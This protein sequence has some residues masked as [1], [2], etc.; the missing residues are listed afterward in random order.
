MHLLNTSRYKNPTI[1]LGSL[2]LCLMTFSFFQSNW[3]LAWCNLRTFPL[4]LSL[5]TT[6]F[7][8]F[9][10]NDRFHGKVEWR[11]PNIFPVLINKIFDNRNWDSLLRIFCFLFKSSSMVKCNS[12]GIFPC[13][14]EADN[15]RL[16]HTQLHRVVIVLFSIPAPFDYSPEAPVSASG[17]VVP[18][19]L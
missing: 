5:V 14:L 18:F 13:L 6:P 9:V 3:N 17:K 2:F 10:E 11:G 1:Y 7:Q 4:V 8:V 15:I 12:N 19:L 16:L